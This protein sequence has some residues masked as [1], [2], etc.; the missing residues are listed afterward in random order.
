MG[1]GAIVAAGNP[2]YEARIK[3]SEHNEK[4]STREGASE[5]LNMSVSALADTELGLSKRMPVE[6]AVIMAEAYG[7]PEL[8]NYFCMHECP[9]G[10]RRSLAE[11]P[12]GIERATVEI[13]KALRKEE[14]Q[15]IK[16]RL[17]DIA[18]DGEVSNDEIP[19]LIEIIDDL[20]ELAVIISKL[21]LIRDRAVRRMQQ[22]K[23]EKQGSM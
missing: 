21:E 20:Q 7:S 22:E 14:V 11:V 18:A 10:S 9:I 3:A 8:L 6:K 17:Q 5:I 15:G 12:V 4:L 1:R 16:H 23:S 19:A 13:T 2:W